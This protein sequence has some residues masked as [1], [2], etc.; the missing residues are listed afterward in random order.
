M[1]DKLRI[2]IVE[3]EAIIAENLRYSLEDLGYQV[4]DTCYNYADALDAIQQ[5]G[6]DLVMLDINLGDRNEMQAGFSL[7]E[8]LND[9]YGKPFIFITAYNDADTIKTASKLL[10][11][12][13]LIK[14]VN[15]ATLFA[16]IQMAIERFD[17]K[18]VAE[19]PDNVNEKPDFFFVKLGTK[20]HKVSW[21]DVYCLEAGKNYVKLRTLAAGLEYP[22]RGSL[23]Y[24][25][26]NMVPTHLSDH[27]IKVNR[28]NY[29]NRKFITGYDNNFVYCNNVKFENGKT[30]NKQLREIL[31]SRL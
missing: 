10:P 7:A 23:S 4:V 11:F 27:F 5:Q 14:P 28:S 31:N 21:E 2:L 26:D 19:K 6:Y 18:V 9:N 20:T 1:R 24:V 16:T 15:N 17:K 30:G 3:D 13:Y 29:L 25:V 22:I 12:G 8:T